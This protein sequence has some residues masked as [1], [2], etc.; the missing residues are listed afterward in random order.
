MS[1]IIEPNLCLIFGRA[2]AAEVTPARLRQLLSGAGLDVAGSKLP[3]KV[4]DPSG[5]A[6]TVTVT[7]G[8]VVETL[9]R[10]LLGRRQKYRES[11][12]GCNTQFEI[13]FADLDEVFCQ[14]LDTLIDIQET[15]KDATQGVIYRSWNDT[16]SG[17]DD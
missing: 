3:L 9:A 16:F 2:P 1:L 6:F 11:L 14:A 7:R 15:L 12:T 13:R 4:R 10:R 17:P 5:T 8:A